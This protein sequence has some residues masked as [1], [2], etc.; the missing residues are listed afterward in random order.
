MYHL[1]AILQK[2]VTHKIATNL[3]KIEIEYDHEIQS[4]V[5]AKAKEKKARMQR[6]QRRLP[7]FKKKKLPK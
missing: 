5:K 4:R 6:K 7:Y 3:Q 2:I 1:H